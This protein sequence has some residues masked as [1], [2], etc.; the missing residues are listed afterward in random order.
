M[1]EP[2]LRDE[3]QRSLGTAYTVQ[4]ELG[5]GGMSRVFVARDE[6]LGRDVVIKVLPR[7]LAAGGMTMVVSAGR[8]WTTLHFLSGPRTI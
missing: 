8:V 1:T 4:R 2:T 5:G 3:L 6:S 7:E